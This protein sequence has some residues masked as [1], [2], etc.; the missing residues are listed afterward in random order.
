[1]SALLEGAVPDTLGPGV[2]VVLRSIHLFP[3][4]PLTSHLPIEERELE[5]GGLI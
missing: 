1:M 2:R 5:A 4:R 3:A